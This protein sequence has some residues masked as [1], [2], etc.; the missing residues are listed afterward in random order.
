MLYIFSDVLINTGLIGLLIL[1]MS[2]AVLPSQVQ[3][4]PPA[5]HSCHIVKYRGERRQVDTHIS[6]VRI[7]AQTST[8]LEK[9][10]DFQSII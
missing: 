5:E 3:L 2:L 7:L 6:R 4:I 10:I 9:I 1:M 8:G